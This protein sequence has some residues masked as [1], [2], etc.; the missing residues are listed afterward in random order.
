MILLDLPTQFQDTRRVTISPRVVAQLAARWYTQDVNCSGVFTGWW[1]GDPDLLV[2]EA[3]IARGDPEWH[4]VLGEAPQPFE[5]E[6]PYIYGSDDA[7]NI[8]PG[9]WIRLVGYWALLPSTPTNPSSNETHDAL[10]TLVHETAFQKLIKD[11]GGLE[12]PHVTLVFREHGGLAAGEAHV[13][14]PAQGR[15][16]LA[17]DR[18]ASWPLQRPRP[19]MGASFPRFHLPEEDE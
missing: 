18:R 3:A 10:T 15:R 16:P 2:V 14:A 4:Q 8:Q 17:L 5:V 7:W 9:F 6:P 13:S 19:L 11:L 1:P 12:E